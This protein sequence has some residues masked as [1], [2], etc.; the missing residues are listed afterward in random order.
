[1]RRMGEAEGDRG[2][3]KIE[4]EEVVVEEEEAAE[5]VMAGVEDRMQ[6]CV[7]DSSPD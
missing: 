2:F 5:V 4:E 6:G 7:L 1:M 3:Y